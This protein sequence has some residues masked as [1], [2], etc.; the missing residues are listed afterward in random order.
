MVKK[1]V[2]ITKKRYFVFFTVLLY[3]LRPEKPN[4]EAMAVSV[5]QT[6][7]FFTVPSSSATTNA[8][9][10]FEALDRGI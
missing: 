7:V 2:F 10:G 3:P 9:A 1:P 8:S 5:K 6:F 4:A